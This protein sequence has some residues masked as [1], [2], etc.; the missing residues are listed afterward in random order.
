MEPTSASL[1][2]DEQLRNMIS[3]LILIGHILDIATADIF[4]DKGAMVSGQDGQGELWEIGALFFHIQNLLKGNKS[5]CLKKPASTIAQALSSIERNIRS[6][7]FM[8]P[9]H[10]LPL[11]YFFRTI[12]LSLN[13]GKFQQENV[14]IKRYQLYIEL[15][16]I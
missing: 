8:L 1:F 5:I 7:L 14:K 10:P 6:I 3:S 9:Q 15:S 16:G 11:V 2:L 4:N 12:L 13:V